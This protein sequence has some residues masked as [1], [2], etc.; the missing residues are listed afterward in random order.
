MMQQELCR[1]GCGWDDGLPQDILHQWK[2]WLEDLDLLATFKVK[3]CIKPMDFGEVRHAQLHHFA[4]ASE[5]GYG[6]VT[7]AQMLN[8]K[9]DI[10]VTLLLG[11][12]RVTPLKAVTIPRLELSAAVL[13]VRVDSML[14]KELNLQLDSSVFWTDS[15]A[16]LKYLNNEDKRFHT[17]VANRIS[18]IRET[19]EPSQWRHVSSKDNPADDA[20]RGMKASDFVKSSRWLEGPG[21]LWK[22]EEDWPKTVLEVLVDS[23]DQ[24]VR[25]E[26]TVNVISVVDVPSPTDQLIAYF[27]SWRRLK[28]AVAWFLRL[29]TMLL[30]QTRQRKQLEVSVVHHLEDTSQNRSK[31]AAKR[32]RVTAES[33]RMILT[34]DD[35]IGAEIAIRYCQGQSHS[36]E[37]SDL[38]SRKATVS[39]QSPV[40]KLDPIL[41]DG[42]LR[43][44]GRLGRGAMPEEAKHPL[45]LCKDPHV[46]MLILKNIHHN[47]GHGGRVYTLSSV[48][49][50]FWITNA[51]SAVRKVI[52]ECSFCRRY[53]GRAIE[54]KMADL[55]RESPS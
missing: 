14:K 31:R 5:G 43:V 41:E 44:G 19:S 15:T 26:A 42:L 25:K 46:S 23:D 47:L 49:K 28:T 54:Q 3:R 51:N 52:A 21:F 29:K 6:T 7:Y 1:R 37:I 50:R 38:S 36:E 55:P 2:R 30:T 45:I 20:S 17:F 8:H 39:Q 35:L 53:N 11:K 32:Q 24:E 10:Q 16:V 4:D 48:R 9:K 13:A 33:N 40:Y 22:H 18:T 34:L 27:S 12:A